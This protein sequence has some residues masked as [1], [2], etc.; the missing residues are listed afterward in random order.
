MNDGELAHRLRLQQIA[1]YVLPEHELNAAQILCGLH[2]FI[3]QWLPDLIH[4]HRTKENIL[5]SIA[6]RI[7]RSI[8]CVRTVHG[9]PEH[10]FH[11]MRN[12]HKRLLHVVDVECGR[13]LQQ[14]VISVSDELGKELSAVYG[15]RKV[16]V[17][18]NGVD[19]DAVCAQVA[20][21]EFRGVDDSTVHVGIVGRLVPVKRVD[22]FL[23]MA[24][25]LRKTHPQRRWQFHV[26]G[27]GPLRTKL[28]NQA[29]ALA[30]NSEVVFHGHRSDIVACL[31]ALNCLVI[32]SDHEGMPM[33]LLEAMSV[34]TPIVGHNIGGMRSA[35]T[36]IT[37]PL[38]VNAHIASAYAT[39]VANICD[40]DRTKIGKQLQ[41][42]VASQ[43]SAMANAQKTYQ[44]YCATLGD[45]HT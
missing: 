41:D 1:V 34:G 6:N 38:L 10:V 28:M 36:S 30:L 7:N 3:R 2:R 27:D 39:T 43:Y 32:C 29:H 4:T 17:I 20:P 16:V 26:F 40:Y 24:A 25:L 8:P 12:W 19:I 23:E 22:I 42:R 11:G 31:A 18:E 35:L 13:R 21:V 15:P 5:G 45:D 9:A 44:L 14:R 33:T 37:A